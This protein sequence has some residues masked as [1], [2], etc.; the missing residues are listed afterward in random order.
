MS[1]VKQ[2]YTGRGAE[3]MQNLQDKGTGIFTFHTM[4]GKAQCILA[5]V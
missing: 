3:A 4:P 1:Y 2:A 5:T